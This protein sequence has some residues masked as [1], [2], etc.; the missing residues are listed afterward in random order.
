MPLMLTLGIVSILVILFVF[1]TIGNTKDPVSR[2]VVVIGIALI[3][4]I[5]LCF[6]TMSHAILNWFSSTSLWHAFVQAK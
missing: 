6:S 2:L 1:G 3:V 4:V 5:V